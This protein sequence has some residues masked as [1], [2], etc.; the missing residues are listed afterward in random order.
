M[1]VLERR[2]EVARKTTKVIKS[3]NIN[4]AI[5][6]EGQEARMIVMAERLAEQQLRDGT[7]S[8]QIITHYLKLATERERLEREKLR[9]DIELT[10]AK[11]EATQSAKRIE[12]MYAE[13][14]K[15]MRSYAGVEDEELQSD[16]YDEVVH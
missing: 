12:E 2:H 10:K 5:T 3:D 8:S 9:G 7:A 11:T 16:D 4:P 14:I 1:N 13:A 6:P 15:S